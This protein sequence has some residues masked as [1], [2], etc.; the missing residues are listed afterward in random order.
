VFCRSIGLSGL[1][2][3]DFENV[4]FGYEMKRMINLLFLMLKIILIGLTDL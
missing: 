4:V 2:D 1:D 3:D